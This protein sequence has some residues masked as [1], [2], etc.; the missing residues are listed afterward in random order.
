MT[1]IFT[2]PTRTAENA[3]PIVPQRHPMRRKYV[4]RRH[5][6]QI[7]VPARE[8]SLHANVFDG[9]SSDADAGRDLP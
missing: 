4:F 9:P 8:L 7:K 5:Q 3:V 1:L 6:R 2:N